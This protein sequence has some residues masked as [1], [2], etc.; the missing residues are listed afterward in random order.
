MNTY[1]IYN[2]YEFVQGL[3]ILLASILGGTCVV[4]ICFYSMEKSKLALFLLIA[5]VVLINVCLF[6]VIYTDYLQIR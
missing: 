1:S 3:S 5:N 4:S 2:F 6:F